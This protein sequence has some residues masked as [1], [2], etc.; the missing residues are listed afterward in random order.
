MTDTAPDA[1]LPRLPTGL[2]AFSIIYGGMVCIAGVLANKQVALGPLA[3]EAG[4]FAFLILVATSSAVA[5]LHGRAI[6]NRLVLIGFIP[7]IMSMLLTAFV[8]TLPAAADM[9]ADRLNAFNLIMGGTPRIWAAGI[10]AYGVSQML[11]VTIFSWLKREGGRLLWLRS[12]VAS[13]LSQVVDTLLFISIAFYGAFP[14]ADLIAGQALAKVVLSI[15]LVPFLIMLL[16]S[17]GRRLD[18]A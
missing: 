7:L 17:I 10:I 6:A 3:V 12:A 9:P 2:F 4:I 18:R 16:V 13:V 15:I 8:L 14:I 1:S 11:N 5:E